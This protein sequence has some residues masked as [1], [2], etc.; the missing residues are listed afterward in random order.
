M[1]HALVLGALLCCT[2]PVA[3]AEVDAERAKL[4]GTWTA[5]SAQRDGKD[6]AELVGHQL[7]FEGERFRISAQGRT[8]YA[9]TYAIDPAPQPPHIDF[10]HVEGQAAGQTWQGIYWFE[11]R[12]LSICDNAADPAKPRPRELAAATGSG[13]VLIVFRP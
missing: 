1:R 7:E 3:A 9:G 2:I 10:R 4:E 8:L 13:H 11:G 12:T 5:M 6:A